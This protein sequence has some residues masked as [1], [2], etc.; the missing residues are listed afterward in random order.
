MINDG[1]GTG[2]NQSGQMPAT[3]TPEDH[4]TLLGF[5]R[6]VQEVVGCA[7]DLGQSGQQDCKHLVA[8]GSGYLITNAEIFQNFNNRCCHTDAILVMFSITFNFFNRS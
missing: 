8:L 1:E 4:L 3:M 7:G 5:H 2:C 6:E